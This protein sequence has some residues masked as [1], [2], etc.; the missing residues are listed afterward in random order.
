MYISPTLPEGGGL[1]P[2]HAPA[3]VSA[4][5]SMHIGSGPG[6]VGLSAMQVKPLVP[7]RTVRRVP[8]GFAA[9]TA[10]PAAT[11]AGAACIALRMSSWSFCGEAGAV[12]D[13]CCDATV[14]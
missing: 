8:S 11:L 7:A 6:V 14:G 12:D 5:A 2:I 9:T 10:A 1:W 13:L 4:E 3:H